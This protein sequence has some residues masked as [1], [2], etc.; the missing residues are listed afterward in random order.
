[1][2]TGVPTAHRIR[3]I[4]TCTAGAAA[5][6]LITMHTPARMMFR[7]FNWD[8][9]IL[10]SQFN[11]TYRTIY[12][13]RGIIIPVGISRNSSI[14]IT[15]VLLFTYSFVISVSSEYWSLS[16]YVTIVP[17]TL[18]Y[19][20]LKST[21]PLLTSRYCLSVKHSRTISYQVQ[22]SVSRTEHQFQLRPIFLRAA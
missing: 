10:G 4:S 18:F 21:R 7:A 11:D 19:S 15:N 2:G 5:A 8:Y 12:S 1:M 14:P 16:R 17:G 3:R 9:S 6:A 13:V 22:P 20:Y